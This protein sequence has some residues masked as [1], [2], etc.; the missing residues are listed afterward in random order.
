ME[1]LKKLWKRYDGQENLKLKRQILKAIIENVDLGIYYITDREQTCLRLS[2]QKELTAKQ[3]GARIGCTSNSVRVHVYSAVRKL[4][5]PCASPKMPKSENKFWKAYDTQGYKA[6]RVLLMAFL[7]GIDL[8]ALRGITPKNRVL[9]ALYRDGVSAQGIEVMLNIK[10]VHLRLQRAIAELRSA[11]LALPVQAEMPREPTLFWEQ[12]A[13]TRKFDKH[14]IL[15]QYLS[16]VELESYYELTPREIELLALLKQS[17]SSAEIQQ[18][19]RISN[20]N[21]AL[22]QAINALRKAQLGRPKTTTYQEFW[23]EFDRLSA[24]QRKALLKP[25]LANLGSRLADVLCEQEYALLLDY[26]R[27]GLL[28]KQLAKKYSHSIM[29]SSV[30]VRKTTKKLRSLTLGEK[31]SDS[32]PMA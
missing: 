21:L 25:V 31:F 27:D 6:R 24:C 18:I 2:I 29:R 26:Y 20:I 4:R 7:K 1:Y 9:L 13:N 30:L 23:E 22:W 16:A 17:K 19:T 5:K 10:N 15:A 3:I 8:E 11:T 12:Y 28:L 14:L 32:F